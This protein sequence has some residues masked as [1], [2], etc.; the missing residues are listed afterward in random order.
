MAEQCVYKYMVFMYLNT[1][2]LQL[3]HVSINSVAMYIF[4]I[5][6]VR[7]LYVCV[8]P[9]PPVTLIS[10]QLNITKDHNILQLNKKNIRQCIHLHTHPSMLYNTRH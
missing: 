4:V 9:L 10:D 2:F 1:A 3:T 5:Q 7:I 8:T 6:F